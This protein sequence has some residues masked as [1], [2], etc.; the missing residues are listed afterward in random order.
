MTEAV[1][2]NPAETVVVA[3]L[4]QF[5]ALLFGWHTARV[6]MLNHL[7]TVPEGTQMVVGEDEPITLEG[8]VLAGFKAGIEMSLM[9][10]GTLPFAVEMEEEPAP[11]A[12]ASLPLDEPTQTH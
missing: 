10:L 8:D 7:L 11:D 4:D 3:D 12:Q 5:T 1:Q 6:K 9:E 2:T